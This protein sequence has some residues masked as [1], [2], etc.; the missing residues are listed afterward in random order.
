MKPPAPARA[1]LPLLLAILLLAAAPLFAG[2][3]LIPI[4]AGQFLRWDPSQPVPFVLDNGPLR[5]GNPFFPAIDRDGAAQLVAD[6]IG[7]WEEV[8]TSTI[9]FEN[10]GFTSV[11]VNASNQAAYLSQVNP[12]GNPVVY[13]ADGS[14]IDSI[15]GMGSS[16]SVLG[17]ASP[18]ACFS[19]FD[20]N[21]PFSECVT[22]P[23]A[24]DGFFDYA[25]IVL[26]GRLAD[27]NPN[28]GFLRAVRHEFGHFLGL[29][30]S[31]I[32]L[33]DMGFGALCGTASAP[34]QSVPLMF[35]IAITGDFDLRRDDETWL[36]FLYPTPDFQQR[37]GRIEGQ[38]FRRTGGFLPGAN[39]I[40]VPVTRGAGGALQES[41]TGQVS[42]VSDFLLNGDGG[43][44]LPGLV[45]GEY[46][47]Y[48]ERI[49][50]DFVG[51]SSVGPFNFFFSDFPR[52]YYNGASESGDMNIDDRMQRQAIT[53]QA[54]QVVSGIDLI[55]NETINDLASLQDDDEEIFLFPEGFTFPFYGRRYAEVVVNS[56]GSLTFTS[57]DGFTGPRDE[58]RHLT[59]PPR[60]APFLT[61]LDP[62]E[63]G[64]VRADTDGN[65]VTFTWDGVPEWSPAGGQPPNT[66]SAT[67]FRNGDIRMRFDS[68]SVTPDG[69]VLGVVGLAPGGGQGTGGAADL[70]A[71][72]QPISFFDAP[73]YQQ[74][75]STDPFD[76]TGSSLLFTPSGVNFFL[77]FPYLVGTEADFT[78]FALTNDEDAEN[79][80]QIEALN[81]AGQQVIFPINP[82]LTRIQAN[83]QLA[84]LGLD[85]FGVNR[86]V[87]RDGWVRI[88]VSRPNVASFFQ[89]G[90]GLTGTISQLDGS[91]AFTEQSQTLYFTR[92]YDGPDSFPAAGG[93]QDA[94]TELSLANPNEVAVTL[95]LRLFDATGQQLAETVRQLPALGCLREGISTLFGQALVQ[96]GFVRVEVDGPG[97]VGFELVRLDDTLLGFNASFGGGQESTSYS[98]QLANGNNGGLSIATSVK[99][100]NVSGE[101]REVT[102]TALDQNGQEVGAFGP[103]ALAANASLQRD[104]G[105]LFGLGPAN[106][107]STE[108]SLRVDADGPGVIGDVVFG[109]PNR[110]RFGAALPLQSQ[111]L[112]RAIFSQVANANVPGNAAFST[113]TGLA[114]HNPDPVQ[115]A[116]ITLRVFDEA[117]LET[118]STVIQLGPGNRAT[119]T[120]A[121]L[122]PSTA[123]Q[124][125]GYIL[126]ESTVPVVAQQLFGNFA[127]SFL[128]A[129][130]PT[131]FQ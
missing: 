96:D 76:L 122:M 109:D 55:S 37:F 129:V 95:R 107:P 81:G 86:Q 30:H 84:R 53:V 48:I 2:G 60:I 65:S 113:F 20:P 131:V 68:I 1:H 8:E 11:D 54:G 61:D 49:C 77:Y 94:V 44:M 82:N 36:S 121:Q 26:N 41:R 72:Q 99:L 10:Q 90:N 35:P 75:L 108:G 85:I 13:D 127:L 62:S 101:A 128:S 93:A 115:T 22:H 19:G 97:A 29:D 83:R 69:S 66:F 16:G 18:I 78:G 124:V 52:D 106:G 25:L 45:D 71:V 102:L 51:G 130:P 80:L 6:V 21:G 70:S 23:G 116:Q 123:G 126:V 88:G 28:G 103:V 40:A 39:V 43:Y 89:L 91:V 117:G 63:A 98:A 47:V 24:D 104:I 100:V 27:T 59:G 111:L 119:G 57:G 58:V 9:R 112:E 110:L 74:F 114:F 12:E 33:P 46:V 125:R 3:P 118:G 67:L 17:F 38:V 14:L 64:V 32:G 92:L 79:L 120:V 105:E 50:P 5:P 56:D 31:Q 7:R 15:I 87:P 42:A 4:G 34:A 73:V